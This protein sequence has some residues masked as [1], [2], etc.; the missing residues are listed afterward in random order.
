M[1]NRALT[2]DVAKRTMRMDTLLEDFAQAMKLDPKAVLAS[3]GLPWPR[4]VTSS[5]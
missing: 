3:H 5:A 4:V 1:I 2:C